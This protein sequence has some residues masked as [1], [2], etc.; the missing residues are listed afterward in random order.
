M[1]LLL[2]LLGRL[3]AGSV[4]LVLLGF[5]LQAGVPDVWRDLRA[6]AYGELGISLLLAG[7][8]A[9]VGSVLLIF[10]VLG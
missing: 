7:L 10:A 5:A 2:P 8:I 3:L 1:T 6:R 9:T 4:G